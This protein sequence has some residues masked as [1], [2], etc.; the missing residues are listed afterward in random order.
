MKQVDF[1]FPLGEYQLK[2]QNIVI[3][4]KSVISV[5]KFTIFELGCVLVK[6]FK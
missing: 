4:I 3:M 5:W 1:D 6:V 2:S